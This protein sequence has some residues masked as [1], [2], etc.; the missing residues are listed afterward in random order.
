MREDA[1]VGSSRGGVGVEAVSPGSP[2]ERAGIVPGDRILS[3]SGR[4]VEDLLDLHF[5]TSRSRFTLAWRDAS[6]AERKKGFRLGG[7]RREFFRSRSAS[8]GAA[9][10]ASSASSTSFRRGFAAPC[11]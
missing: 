3:V 2:A 4:P 7:R 11:T 10:D 6:G 8:G 9:T 1:G 5:L